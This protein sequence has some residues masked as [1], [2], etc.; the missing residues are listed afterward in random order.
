MIING[1]K[2][3]PG[4]FTLISFLAVSFEAHAQQSTHHLEKKKSRL[5]KSIEYADYLIDDALK[6]KDATLQDL[7]LLQSKIDTRKELIDQYLDEQNQIFEAIFENMLQINEISGELNGLKAEYAL[8]VNS[9]Y[10]NHNFYKR[11]VY[12]LSAGDLNQAYSRFNYYKYYARRR[13]AQIEHIK[14][15]EASYFGEVEKLESRVDKNQQLIESLNNE[16][17]QLEAEINLKNSMIE[18]LNAQVEQLTDEQHQNRESASALEARIQQIIS[19]EGMDGIIASGSPE[20]IEAP[21]IED[22]QLSNGFNDNFGRLPWPLDR[23]IISSGFGEQSHPDLAGVLI[24]NNGI[25]FLTHKDAVVT[26]VFKG[27]VTRVISVPNFNHV[28]ILRH[29]EFLSVYSNL[30]EVYVEPGMHVDTRQE[31]GIVFTDDENQKAELHFEIW[32]GK[33]IQDP[34]K[35][36]APAR[37]E[38]ADTP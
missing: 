22:R 31:L 13:N 33:K 6:K 32:N 4:I 35:W 20:L 37:L 5:E 3:L 2:F 16:Y 38:S 30:I 28:V 17:A 12:V 24:K 15:V 21:S 10:Q 34:A 29:G 7:A 27:E 11:L 1:L 23:A 36:V 18:N 8:M 19:E 25:N 26:S 9:A 14:S